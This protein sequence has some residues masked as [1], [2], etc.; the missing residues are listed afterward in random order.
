MD[1]IISPAKLLTIAG[2][3]TIFL[4]YCS[5]SKPFY[6]NFLPEILITLATQFLNYVW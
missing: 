2:N 4:I 5:I 1:G 6:F 3:L